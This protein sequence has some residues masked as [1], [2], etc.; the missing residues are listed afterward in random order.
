MS[1]DQTAWENLYRIVRGGVGIMIAGVS[2][3]N[4]QEITTAR[5]VAEMAKAGRR[6]PSSTLFSTSFWRIADKP[7]PFISWPARR[8]SFPA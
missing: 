3:R 7:G 6:S 4:V 2:I 1:T 8:T 5:V